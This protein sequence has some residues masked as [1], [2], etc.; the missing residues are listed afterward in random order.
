M[1]LGVLARV[2]AGATGIDDKGG[3]WA[4]TVRVIEYCAK[5]IG[6]SENLVVC[7][8]DPVSVIF[9]FISET[10]GAVA[11][12]FLSAESRDESRITSV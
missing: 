11:N 1:G 12:L 8:V 5:E 7:I 3:R 9:E 10:G 2:I 4:A 6:F